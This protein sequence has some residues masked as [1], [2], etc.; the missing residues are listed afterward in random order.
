MKKLILITIIPL[1]CGCAQFQSAFNQLNP[2][3]KQAFG[4]AVRSLEAAGIADI[5]AAIKAL[6]A[7]WLPAGGVYD[8]LAAGVIHSYL[9]AHPNTPDQIK[10]V[11]EALATSLQ[12][13][14]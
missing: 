1:F 12:T 8:Q 4:D 5:P 14:P 11:L 10:K 3:L 2:A 6:R 9:A 13:T 7:K